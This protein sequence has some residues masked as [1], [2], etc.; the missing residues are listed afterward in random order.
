MKQHIDYEGAEKLRDAIVISAV[1]ELKL[2]YAARL[3]NNYKL[4]RHEYECQIRIDELECFILSPWF[5]RLTEGIDPDKVLEHC[6]NAAKESVEKS[7]RRGKK[8]CMI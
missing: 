4:K 7:K 8:T 5:L 1:N 3:R 2:M 6:R